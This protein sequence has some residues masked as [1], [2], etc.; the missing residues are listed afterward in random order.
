M[1]KILNDDTERLNLEASYWLDV[2]FIEKIGRMAPNLL[3]LSFRRMPH[4]SNPNFA[5]VFKYL[6]SLQAVDLSDCKNLYPTA[7][8]LMLRNN[9]ATLQKIQLYNDTN[10]VDDTAL[11]LISGCPNLS[12][13]DVSFAKQITD[14]GLVHFSDKALPIDTLVVSGCTGMSSA[15]MTALLNCCTQTLV[16]FEMQYLDQET[17]KGD[18]F[19]KLGY[20]WQLEFL[21]IAGCPFVDDMAMQNL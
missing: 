11:R 6:K 2:S 14:A 18:M 7:L 19:L 20:A 10:A 16:D 13:L 17:M 15:G 1:M 21:D 8:Q 5:E 4:I 12:F 9:Q 3:E